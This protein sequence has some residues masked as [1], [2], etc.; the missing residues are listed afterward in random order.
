MDEHD[1]A[2]AA[3]ARARE[4]LQEEMDARVNTVRTLVNAG[5]HAT[6]IEAQARDAATQHQA[7]YRAAID[8]GWTETGLRKAGI[9][10]P[11]TGA[12]RRRP[13]RGAAS[14]GSEQ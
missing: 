14:Q 11:G 7:A 9:R 12:T 13:A 8:A 5:Q 2:D 1:T 3:A 6:N 10:P 4:L